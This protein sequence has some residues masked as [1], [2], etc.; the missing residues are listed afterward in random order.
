VAA[1]TPVIEEV[2]EIQ[3]MVR[4]VENQETA[5]A[6]GNQVIQGSLHTVSAAGYTEVENQLVVHRDSVD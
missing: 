4:A 6:V 3:E 1:G 2:V 5:E